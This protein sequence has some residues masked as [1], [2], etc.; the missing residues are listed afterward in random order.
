ML[1]RKKRKPPPHAF[2]PGHKKV[3]GRKKGTPN[4]ISATVKEAVKL[5]FDEVGGVDYLKRVAARDPKTFVGVVGKL[6]PTE[7]TGSLALS[8]EE[9]LKLLDE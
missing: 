4:R 5:A 3:G 6:I 9:A 1:V 7:I 8:H 2:K